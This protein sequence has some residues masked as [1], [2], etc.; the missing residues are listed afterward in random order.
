M[1]AIALE[2]CNLHRRLSLATLRIMGTS[3]PLVMLAVM[4]P[5]W[6]LSASVKLTTSTCIV[7]NNLFIPQVDVDVQ[8]GNDS[9]DDTHR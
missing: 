9:D 3:T 1:M 8:H 6:F 4:L 2:N 7:Q 5:T